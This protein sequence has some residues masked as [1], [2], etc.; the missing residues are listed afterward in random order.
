MDIKQNRL[1]TND[2]PQPR[3]KHHFIQRIKLRLRSSA[4]KKIDRFRDSTPAVK[5]YVIGWILFAA[6]YPLILS[7]P[8]PYKY[9]AFVSILLALMVAAVALGLEL[10]NPLSRLWGTSTRKF[11]F[12]TIFSGLV[13]FV[14]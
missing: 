13:V 6:A 5:L 8:N 3:A 4:R 10:Y 11:L 14:A 12:G 1:R 7:L 9:L 2:S